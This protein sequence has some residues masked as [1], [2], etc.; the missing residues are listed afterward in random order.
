LEIVWNGKKIKSCGS[1]DYPG[2]SGK[3][4]NLSNRFNRFA[5]ALEELVGMKRFL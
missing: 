1:N 5:T 4:F 2:Q 3:W